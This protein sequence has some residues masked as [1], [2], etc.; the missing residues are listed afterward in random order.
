MADQDRIEKLRRMTEAD[1]SDEMAHF[2]LGT[3]LLEA[4]QAQDAGPYLQR[5]L[6]LNSQNS[7]A[8][9]LLGK[10]QIA[11]GH[12][13]LAVRTLMDGYRVAHRKGDM[14]PMQGMETML[15]EL[16]APV[17]SVAEKKEPTTMAAGPGG[18]VCRR[19]GGGGPKLKE[20]P[21]KG[22]LGEK[23]LATVCES[24]WK[25]WVG[26]GTKVINELRL[27]MFDPQAQEMYDK[28]MKEFL[29]IE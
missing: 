15:K 27:P 8:Y 18:F 28:H 7:K 11:T 21:F 26:M 16:G 4:G 29:L 17:P 3:A 24:C 5:V 2:S 19:C 25:E 20:R 14:M 10:V 13:D 12:R 1:P 23:I 22:E 9:E 6:A